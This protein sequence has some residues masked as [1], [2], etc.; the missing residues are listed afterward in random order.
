MALKILVERRHALKFIDTL[1]V[2]RNSFI[3]NTFYNLFII[4][5]LTAVPDFCANCRFLKKLIKFGFKL[6]G[7]STTFPQNL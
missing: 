7:F 3:F 1:A 6:Q 4:N 5:N 2:M